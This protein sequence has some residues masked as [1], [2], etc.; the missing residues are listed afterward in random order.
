MNKIFV[1]FGI[2]ILFFG[3][4]L[5]PTIPAINNEESQVEVI[6][7]SIWHVDDDGNEYPNPDFNNIQDAI[8]AASGGDEIRV[9]AGFY[10]ENVNVDKTLDLI[11][12]YNGTSTIDGGGNGNTVKLSSASIR[13]EKFTI[14]NSGDYREGKVYDAGLHV[15]SSLNTIINNNIIDN[16]GTGI[17]ISAS[18][19]N[20]IRLN[21]ISNNAYDGISLFSIV[22]GGNT[23]AENTIENNAHNGIYLFR[24]NGN[25]IL[26]NTISGNMENGIYFWRSRLNTIDKNFIG[27][28]GNYGIYFELLCIGNSINFNNISGNT[29]QGVFFKFQCDANSIT[30]NNFIDNNGE[31]SFLYCCHVGYLSC[32]LNGW[33]ENYW[34]DYDPI[35]P[36][37]WYIIWG[38][39]GFVP[40]PNFDLYPVPE[41]YVWPPE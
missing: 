1:V 37:W 18:A 7:P 31:G 12:G 39:W 6:M 29:N 14:Q 33:R 30:C 15:I 32:F 13:I 25:F 9:Y 26:E 41:P 3:A 23:I 38:R 22:S 4:S 35:I 8:D 21:T 2:V 40:W 16:L 36:N 20:E 10:V 34:D 24:G 19:G 17:F 5:I 28:S 27:N 11:G